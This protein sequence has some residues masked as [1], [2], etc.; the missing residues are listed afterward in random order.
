MDV[1]ELR[2]ELHEAHDGPAD[3]AAVEAALE[4]YE[5]EIDDGAIPMDCPVCDE[6]VMRDDLRDH[7]LDDH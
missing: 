2:D 7:L 5:A 3:P 1:E 6:V 4:K